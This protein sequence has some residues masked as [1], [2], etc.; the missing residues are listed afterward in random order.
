MYSLL[1]V[2]IDTGL[3][4]VLQTS[5]RG[6]QSNSMKSLKKISS[7]KISSSSDGAGFFGR[8][9]PLSFVAMLS[10]PLLPRIVE[11]DELL[12][13]FVNLKVCNLSIEVGFFLG[14]C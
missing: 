7:K 10:T 5:F 3:L 6:S 12:C 8:D 9:D 2:R 1:W 11:L 14:T 13:I 4:S